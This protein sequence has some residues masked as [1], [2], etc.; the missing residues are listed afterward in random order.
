MSKIPN[1]VKWALGAFIAIW[2]PVYW[3]GY[4]LAHFL[5]L[6][7][8]LLIMAALAAIFEW[9]YLASMACCGG[10]VTTSLWIVDFVIK[11]AMVISGMSVS[12][13]IAY[14]FDA[15][16]P[17]VL[18]LFSLFHLGIPFLLIWLVI[19]LGYD[20][21]SWSI[22][23]LFSWIV[24]ALSVVFSSPKT[25]INFVYGYEIFDWWH[26]G[27]VLYL[28]V[29]SLLMALTIFFTHLFLKRFIRSE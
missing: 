26:Y 22:Q 8:L 11:S 16:R 14:M 1:W 6:S 27:A 28:V 23:V 5:W 3:V 7:D 24:I 10:L 18:R 29:G 19:R 2:I 17:L 13:G 15:T 9:R 25:N 21:R 4:G 20:R 12:G